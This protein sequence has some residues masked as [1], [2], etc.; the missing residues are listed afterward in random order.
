[1]KF[2]K[3]KHGVL[4]QQFYLILT[5]L[6]DFRYVSHGFVVDTSTQL[7]RITTNFFA[8]KK[9]DTKTT[10]SS[11][12][13]LSTTTTNVGNGFQRATGPGTRDK[14]IETYDDDYRIFPALQPEVINTLV[15]ATKRTTSTTT[16]ATAPDSATEDIGVETL[17]TEIFQRLDQIYGFPSF[18]HDES[19]HF[20]LDDAAG[21]GTTDSSSRTVSP[22]D[23]LVSSNPSDPDWLSAT[24]ADDISKADISTADSTTI[25]LELHKLP[26]FTEIR[27]LH[28]DPMILS[29]EN[30]FT[31][32]ECD[33]YIQ[34]SEPNVSG[35]G[36]RNNDVMQSRSPTVGKDT[37]AKA[38]RT[39]TTFYHKY[40]DVPQ[41]MSKA[42]RLLGLQ[43]I[44]QWEEPQTVRYRNNEKF[45]W[46]LD[47]LGPNEQ[48]TSPAGQRI[49]TLLVYLTDLKKE[50]GGATLFRDLKDNN[51]DDTSKYLRIQPKKGMAVLFFPSAGGIQ[52]C[53]FDIRTLHC[54]EVVS[55]HASN[56]K[57]IAQLWL[58]Q[59]NYTPTAPPGNRHC[60][61]YSAINDYCNQY[62][63][64]NRNDKP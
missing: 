48:Q 41:L 27:T 20:A 12:R 32:E 46:H 21:T 40:E 31:P 38:Q 45:T 54:G 29:I 58:R 9:K 19:I 25:S 3:M 5:S 57:W 8:T 35:G 7:T 28:I 62:E 52:D 1:L 53:P 14:T 4:Y 44:D 18:N 59:R 51:G 24:T 60:D 42:S 43:T 55:N 11:G 23:Y 13:K 6:I 61:A 39:S 37:T 33:L 50:D 16:T 30:F 64:N 49:A 56:E 10:T 22:I 17:S 26:P 34:Q 47:A 2:L 15:P 63:K 36:R